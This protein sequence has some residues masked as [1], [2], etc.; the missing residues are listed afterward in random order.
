MK[1]N[2][3]SILGWLGVLIS[4]LFIIIW[5]YWGVIENFHEGWYSES[6]WENLFML[7]FQYLLIPIFF[8]ILAVI[9]L[10]WKKMGVLCHAALAG[11]CLWFFK[12]ASFSVLGLLIL[13]PI[14]VLCLLYFFGEITHKKGAY[15]LIVTV[16]LIIILAISVPQGIK[17][18]KRLDDGNMSMQIV[19]GN[20]V[21]LAWHPGARDGRIKEQL[22]K[23]PISFANIYLKMV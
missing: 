9:A 7:F 23:K 18:S 14:I 12:G 6:I 16:P 1:N 5:S 10:K 11:F 21:T 8:I 20:G 4:L 22:G 2:I 13:F 3:K 17:I 19:E 15:L